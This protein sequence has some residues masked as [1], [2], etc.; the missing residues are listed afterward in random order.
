MAAQKSHL[1]PADVSTQRGRTQQ[2][3]DCDV[4]AVLNADGLC[5]SQY[6]ELVAVEA[7][8]ISWL[9]CCD[10][11]TERFQGKNSLFS[12]VLR[13][14]LQKTNEVLV[15]YTLVTHFARALTLAI[16]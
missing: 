8:A 9:S 2:S 15:L 11:G 5:L 7:I 10:G 4:N 16:T 12:K 3:S 1:S 6:F 13:F 14:V